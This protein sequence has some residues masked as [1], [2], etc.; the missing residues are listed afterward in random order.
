MDERFN[1]PQRPNGD[2]HARVATTA[3][4]LMFLVVIA[5]VAWPVIKG[6]INYAF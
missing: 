2:E 3:V 6:V 4:V 1:L 5:V